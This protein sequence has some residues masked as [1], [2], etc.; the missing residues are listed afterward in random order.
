M[1]IAPSK[2]LLLTSEGAASP[3][4][5]TPRNALNSEVSMN[6]DLVMLCTYGDLVVY[7]F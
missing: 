7:V 1:C 5:A 3:D 4:G 6:F 2:F